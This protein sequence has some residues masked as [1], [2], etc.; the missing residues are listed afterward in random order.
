MSAS[1]VLSQNM[2]S[3]QDGVNLSWQVS[4]MAPLKEVTLIYYKNT[5]DSNLQS[6]DISPANSQQ[7][8]NLESGASY[9]FQLQITDTSNV[10]NYSNTLELSAPYVLSAPVIASFVGRDGAIDLVVQNVGNTLSSADSVEFVLKKSNNALFWIIKQY[11]SS[12]NY[13]LSGADNA[14]LVNNQSYRIACMYQPAGNNALYS[15]PSDMSN[16]MTV[17]PSNLPNVPTNVSIASVGTVS[18]ALK[19]MWTQPSDYSEWSN[20]FEIV[21]GLQ[22]SLTNVFSYVVVNTSSIVE[23]TF[24]GLSRDTPYRAN[25]MYRNASGDGDVSAP[26]TA[27]M[28]TTV[29]DAPLIG[30]YQEGDEE[31]TVNWSAPAYAGNSAITGYLLYRNASL[32]ATLGNVLTAT[33]VRTGFNGV[34]ATYTVK[35][36]NAIGNSAL[37]NEVIANPYGDC[38]V[39]NVVINGKT[40]QMTFKPNGRAIAKIF[41]VAMDS[42]PS[43]ADVPTNFFFEVPAGSISAAVTGTF[44]LSK[45]FSSFSDNVSFYCVIC[46]NANSS[47]FLKS[48]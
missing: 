11:Q 2:N 10:T 7:N 16:S 21:L 41:I 48:A 32:I 39:E 6:L 42:N 5:S 46:N 24:T 3:S 33:D 25:V 19:V 37:S 36:V 1:I 40:L 18:P 28:L 13:T 8:L 45:T 30:S 22:N 44:N 14:L 20:S 12:G 31:I 35:A 23:Y 9:S 29:A 38:S 34:D 17:I 27:V 15:S 43:E 47:A 26:L 4:N